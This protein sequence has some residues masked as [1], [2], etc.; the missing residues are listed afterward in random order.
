MKLLESTSKD[1]LHKLVHDPSEKARK[2]YVLDGNQVVG[3]TTFIKAG[4]P[5]SEGL[6]NWK[7]KEGA[8]YT[9]EN[10]FNPFIEKDKV[11]ENS[12]YAWKRRSKESSDIG[13]VVHEYAFLTRSGKIKKAAKLLGKYEGSKN[14]SQ[15]Q[16]SIYKFDDF[17][18]GN[19]DEIIALEDIVASPTHLFAGRFDCLSRRDG[20]TTLSDYKTSN[21]FYL[22][23]F[24][25]GAAYSLAIKEW[26]GIE[27]DQIEVLRF[28][29]EDGS[30]D[31]R[32][33]RDY[34]PYLD[35]AMRCLAT[36]NF[37]KTYSKLTR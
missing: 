15:I 14:W 16:N 3:T 31:S 11:I 36:Y 6:I 28:G 22:D 34:S 30:F 1:G 17:N 29:K 33:V 19:K 4:L 8:K 21:G 18:K 10:A 5:T 23:Q 2:R 35:Q 24:I 37:N 26:M 7:V 25:Q 13:T 27:V 32:V 20:L 9:L 12:V